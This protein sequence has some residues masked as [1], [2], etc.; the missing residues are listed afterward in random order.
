M[1]YSDQSGLN[2]GRPMKAWQMQEAKA[3][4]SEVVKCAESDGPQYITHHGQSV[5]VVVSQAMY[6]RL[7][8]N[9]QGLEDL[10][11]RSPL[12]DADDVTFER[13]PSLTRDLSL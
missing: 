3:R 1:L 8:C 13:D 6:S 11:R 9:E 4:L 5:A 10:M 2:K 7:T 12:F